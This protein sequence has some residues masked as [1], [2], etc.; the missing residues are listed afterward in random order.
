MANKKLTDLTELITPAGGDFL[1][2]VDVSDT[3][4]SAQGTSKK[5]KQSNFVQNT[6]LF[7]IDYPRLLAPQ[8]DFEL[9]LGATAVMAKVNYNATYLPET[10]NLTGELNQFVQTGTTVVFNQ[11]LQIENYVAILYKTI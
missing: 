7:F 9:P 10:S 2:I 5:I 8:T 3:T 4:E 11:E 1:Y 6:G